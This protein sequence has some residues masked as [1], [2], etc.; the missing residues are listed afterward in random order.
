MQYRKDE[1][2]SDAPSTAAGP[3]LPGPAGV[4]A[5][6]FLVGGVIVVGVL[7]GSFATSR[8]EPDAA[9]IAMV[10]DEQIGD[11]ITT[12]SPSSQPAAQQKY[13]QCQYPMGVITVSTPGNPAGGTV[14]FR[15]SKYTS[16]KFHV[17][18]KPQQIAIPHPLPESGGLDPFWV[19]GEAKGLIVSLY[20]TARMEPVNGTAA[21]T[22]RWHPRAPCK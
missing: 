6:A 2:R 10:A 12:L 19:E 20:P 5:M 11:A 16:P 9:V 15:T 3:A 14:S 8:S 18:D 7:A 1:Q 21:I 4:A 13:R 22:V 17:T